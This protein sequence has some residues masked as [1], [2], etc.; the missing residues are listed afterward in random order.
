[1]DFTIFRP[2]VIFGDPQGKMEIA[3]Q[4]YQDMISPPVPAVGFCNGL[5]PQ[6][7][8]IMMSPVHVTAVAQA[9]AAAIEDPATIGRT[10]TLGGPEALSWS[11]MLQRVASAA[12]R[13]KWIMPMPIGLMKMAAALLDWLPVFPVTGDQL[14]MLSEGNTA[15]PTDLETLTG[16][17]G[18]AFVPENLA[19]L[20]D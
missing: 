5:D 12:G 1:M 18:Q 2:S 19:Y 3:T 9:F 7:G 6:K 14:T 15:P 10:Y 20:V 13:D 11:E 8:P 4:L 17:A 16:S